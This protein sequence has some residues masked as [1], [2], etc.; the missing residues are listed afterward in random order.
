M[1]ML[2][3]PRAITPRGNVRFAPVPIVLTLN[4]RHFLNKE[5]S[6][7]RVP[8]A[9]RCPLAMLIIEEEQDRL[10]REQSQPHGR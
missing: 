3:K 1:N 8:S 5:I 4:Q 2:T 9:N 7:R 10:E 6:R